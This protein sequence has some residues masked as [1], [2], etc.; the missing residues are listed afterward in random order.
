MLPAFQVHLHQPILERVAQVGKFD[1]RHPALACGTTA[2]KVFIHSP[3]ENTFQNNSLVGDNEQSSMRFLKI[4]RTVTAL[5]AGKFETTDQGDTLVI[6]TQSSLLAYDVEKNSD[7]FYKDVPDGVSAMLFASAPRATSP[8]S[9]SSQMVVVGGNCSLQGF[10]RDGGELFWTVTGDHVRALTVC[11][12]TGHGRSELVAGSDDFEI[13]AF[14]N[15]EAVFN[16]TETSQVLALTSIKKQFYGYALQN[17]TVGVYKGKHRAWRI[18]SKNIPIAIHSFDIDGDGEKEIVMGWSNGKLESRKILN[19]EAV[20]KE[21]FTSPV[22]A[23]VTADY[24]MDGK[25]EIICC[26]ADGEIR[27]YFTA[28][29]DFSAPGTS[30]NGASD[31]SSLEEKEVA[32]LSKHRAAL[33]IEMKALEAHQSGTATATGKGLKIR[34]DTKIKVRSLASKSAKNF[35]LEVSTE[36]DAVIKMV[37]VFESEVGIFAG[38]SYVVRP[39]TMS[40][41]VR[42]PLN[43]DKPVAANLEFKV[44]VGLRGHHTSFHVFECSF[45]V[46]KF[47]AFHHITGETSLQTNPEGF[48]RFSTPV[49]PQQIYSWLADA[50]CLAETIPDTSEANFMFRSLRD[51]SRLNI[52]VT[53]HDTELRTDNMELAAELV[54][55]MCAFLEWRELESVA[56]FPRQMKDFRNLLVKVDESNAIRLKLTGEMADDSNQVKNLIIRAEDS[57]ILND[58]PRMRQFYSELFSLNNQLLGEYTKR[59]TNHQVLLDA[60]KE[61]NNMIQL[62]ARLRFGSAKSTVIAACRKAIKNNNI[63]GLFHIVKTG[64]EEH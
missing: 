37:I 27:G 39:A 5:A 59:S 26:S 21:M 17:G 61:V 54:Q 10:G 63:H 2:G 33:H 36:N 42:F 12:V 35:E 60:L 6:G 20:Y 13:R 24:R 56:E 14:Q 3:N 55:H 41:T 48:V 52:S 58:M 64:K 15:E 25:D 62:A 43:V 30:D 47:A 32:R 22:A 1:G 44:L 18:K 49:K 34:A 50:F 53:P 40:S 16:C 28:T 23:L 38:E 9:S 11:D 7:I 4:N 46:P 51:D 45:K 19:G 8:L 57:R 29:G 31:K